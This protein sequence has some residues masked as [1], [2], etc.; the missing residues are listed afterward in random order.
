MDLATITITSIT[1]FLTG[2]IAGLL[3]A[4]RA[5]KLEPVAALRQE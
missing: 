5:M 3:P 4:I 2:V 1:L